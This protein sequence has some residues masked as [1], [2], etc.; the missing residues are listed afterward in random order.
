MPIVTVSRTCK[1]PHKR[2]MYTKV[3]GL[4]NKKKW[5]IQDFYRPQ[6]SCEGYV[7][8]RVCDSVHRG[9]VLSQHALQVVSQHTLQWGRVCSQGVSAPGGF[10]SHGVCSGRVPAPMGGACSGG[11]LLWGVPARGVW[12]PPKSRQLLL[13]TV[14]ILLEC[15]LVQN[16][17]PEH[18][19]RNDIYRLQ[20]KYTAR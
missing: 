19:R 4:A 1:K 5:Q 9:G 8:T 11:C 18:G 3:K 6:R 10:C 17:I 15:I 2:K 16:E 20:T 14:R 7:F 12:R 13:R